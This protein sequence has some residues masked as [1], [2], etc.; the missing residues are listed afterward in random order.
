MANTQ[1]TN[2]ANLLKNYIDSS[3]HSLEVAAESRFFDKMGTRDEA[4][5]LEKFIIT[6]CQY[7]MSYTEVAGLI[8]FMLDELSEKDIQTLQAVGEKLLNV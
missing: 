3:D 8:D 6:D 7:K 4:K 1:K 2:M 5:A